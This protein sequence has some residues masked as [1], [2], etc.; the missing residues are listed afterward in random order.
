MGLTAVLKG[1]SPAE[2]RGVLPKIPLVFRQ[3]KGLLQ[4]TAIPFV[5]RSLYIPFPQ[6]TMKLSLVI[7]FRHLLTLK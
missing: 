6:K 1:F 3:A 5:L 2:F 7:C 4:K